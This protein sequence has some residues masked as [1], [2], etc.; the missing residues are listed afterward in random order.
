MSSDS[1]DDDD[2]VYPAWGTLDVEKYL[3]VSFAPAPFTIG[4][5]WPSFLD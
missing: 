3:L 4:K 2:E 1:A 5:N